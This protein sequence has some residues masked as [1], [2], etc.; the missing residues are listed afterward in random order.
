MFSEVIKREITKLMLAIFVY[1]N[2][3]PAFCMQG[4]SEYVV[5]VERREKLNDITKEI[6]KGFA[7]QVIQ[8]EIVQQAL[9]QTTFTPQEPTE[10]IL[11]EKDFVVPFMALA[12]YTAS[13]ITEQAKLI[14]ILQNVKATIE[15]E[16]DSQKNSEPVIET[17]QLET[18]ISRGFCLNIPELG[19]LLI[20]PDGD[21]VFDT[22]KFIGAPLKISAPSQVILNNANASDIEVEAAAAILTGKTTAKINSLCFSANK[23]LKSPVNGLFIDKESELEVGTLTLEDAL[24]LNTG[25]LTVTQS[26]DLNGGYFFNTG[27]LITSADPTSLENISY[28]YNGEKGQINASG[29]LILNT[30]NMSNI[31]KIKAKNMTIIA[32]E[33]LKNQGDIETDKSLEISSLTEF[34]NN[35]TING[36]SG[37]VTIS[38]EKFEHNSGLISAAE[39][40]FCA[41]K[42]DI[43][44]KA[45]G[46][47]VSFHNNVINSGSINFQK[48]KIEGIFINL[49]NDTKFEQKVELTGKIAEIQ[50][51]GKITTQEIISSAETGLI[52][53]IK[54]KN[55]KNSPKGEITATF[56]HSKKHLQLG[57]NFPNLKN[58]KTDNDAKLLINSSSSVNNLQ[59]IENSGNTRILHSVVK[60]TFPKA[61]Y[62]LFE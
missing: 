38:G 54:T 20:S 55:L 29:K 2:L 37:A 39:I 5:N 52:G 40:D 50:N 14:E 9:Q 13:Q 26:M 33:L 8:R 32:S 46:Q 12:A 1:T 30:A 21:V 10:K 7:I 34:I 28:F 48:G 44:A 24:L 17:Q 61:P 60:L 42:T 58:I 6:T 59:K 22:S 31:G 3:S 57:T 47:E 19:D 36:K 18:Q 27:N 11:F 45:V 43:L 53:D 56:A 41:K 49:S 15:S 23:D 35:G 62:I 25:K 51:S 16:K 4:M